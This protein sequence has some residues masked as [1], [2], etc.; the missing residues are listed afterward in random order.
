MGDHR[1]FEVF[2][3]FIKKQFSPNIYKNI[4]D[5]AG[6]QGHLNKTLKS[7]GFEN[8]ITF[9]TRKNKIKNIQYK[10][11]LFSDDCDFKFDLLVGM[12]PDNA[13]DVII[14]EAETQKIPFII[15]PCCILPTITKFTMQRSYTNWCK[16]LIKFA[17]SLKFNVKSTILS[18][19]GSNVVIWGNL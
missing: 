4:A 12:H 2:A 6:G 8:I 18:I 9:D 14:K 19:S 5:V 3:K 11:K 17:E 7:Y 10:R 13:T 1:R 15:V 16:H